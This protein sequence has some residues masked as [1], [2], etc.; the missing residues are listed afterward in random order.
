LVFFCGFYLFCGFYYDWVAAIGTDV[1]F[2][3]GTGKAIA[4]VALQ[5]VFRVL[6]IALWAA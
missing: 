3:T 4:A 2:A 1:N 5:F 6:V